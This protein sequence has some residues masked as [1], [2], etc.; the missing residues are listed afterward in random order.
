MCDKLNFLRLIV[1]QTMMLIAYISEAT[2]E[3][4][5]RRRREYGGGRVGGRRGVGM[6]MMKKLH[7]L[8]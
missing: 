4:S 8:Q 6:K 5:W 7:I 2:R 1:N 3:N